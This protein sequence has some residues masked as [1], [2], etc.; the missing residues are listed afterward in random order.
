MG[1][2]SNLCAARGNPDKVPT[3]TLA[4]RYCKV[5]Y[6][7][8]RVAIRRGEG[9]DRSGA[10]ERRKSMAQ[11]L[12]VVVDHDNQTF[13]IE[14]PMTDDTSWI[15]KVVEARKA[16]RNVNCSSAADSQDWATVARKAIAQFRYCLVDAV[17]M[18]SNPN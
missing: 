15:N 14:G 2:S 5:C 17:E 6:A 7:S 10:S 4:R 13:S 8:D 1:V 9:C 12:L 11:F 18:P 3:E 16:G